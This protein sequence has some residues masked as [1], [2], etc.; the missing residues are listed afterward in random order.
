VLLKGIL[1]STFMYTL[2]VAHRINSLVVNSLIPRYFNRLLT[3]TWLLAKYSSI[4]NPRHRTLMPLAS[5]LRTSRRAFPNDID[6]TQRVSFG[7]LLVRVFD[8][9]TELGETYENVRFPTQ[10]G[11]RFRDALPI[12]IASEEAYLE[13]QV[14]QEGIGDSVHDNCPDWE[15]RRELLA[16][17]WWYERYR[18]TKF[19][20]ARVIRGGMAHSVDEQRAFEEHHSEQTTLKERLKRIKEL[21]REGDVPL[22]SREVQYRRVEAIK[23][24]WLR[25]IR[26]ANEA[27]ELERERLAN[28]EYHALA[29]ERRKA[30]FFHSL[31]EMVSTVLFLALYAF[32]FVIRWRT[33]ARGLYFGLSLLSRRCQSQ[34]CIGNIHDN[35]NGNAGSVVMSP[36]PSCA[37]TTTGRTRNSRH[38]QKLPTVVQ[39]RRS[40]RL[41]AKQDAAPRRSLR[42]K[43]QQD[44]VPQQ[45]IAPQS[46]VPRR[47]ARIAAR[48]CATTSRG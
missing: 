4:K 26:W 22:E 5:A 38:R 27:L 43:A 42:L 23:A 2:V 34:P 32:A 44:T 18:L 33:T 10:M 6:S 7:V 12:T 36:R 9:S 31:Q 14:D 39:L 28:F 8:R 25:T 19:L 37:T 29:A 15:E 45:S 1:R 16:G 48:K 3:H 41:I 40:P 13:Y 30:A 47:S 35:L 46:A 11:Q 24:N 21:A 17:Q 20:N